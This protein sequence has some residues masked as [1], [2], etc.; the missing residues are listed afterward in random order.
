ML[1]GKGFAKLAEKLFFKER[2]EILEKFL[3]YFCQMSDKNTTNV[4]SIF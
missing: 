2:S 3:S 4:A 1:T